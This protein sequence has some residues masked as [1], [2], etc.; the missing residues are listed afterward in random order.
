MAVPTPAE[1]APVLAARGLAHRFG[2]RPA[3]AVDELEIAP[4][5]LVAIIGPNGA[6]KTTL[7]RVLAGALEPQSGTVSLPPERIGWV[8]QQPAI[9]GT[10]TVR[11]NLE[12]FCALEGIPSHDEVVGRMLAQTALTDR[13]DTRVSELSGGNRQRVNIAAGLL[14]RP[15]VLLLD[16]PSASLDPRQRGR[17]WA[18]I[19]GLVSEGTAVVFTTHDVAE[20]ERH[21]DRVLVL[22][23]GSVVFDGSPA[24]LHETARSV[25]GAPDADFETAFVGLLEAREQPGA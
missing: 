16:E 23:G 8:P 11:E 6:G 20:A 2:D 5:T 22:V 4:G 25:S 9:Y 18:F 10:L 3:L 7:L 24:A 13:A 17:M 15:D 1:I 21:A 14:A 19:G 12:L